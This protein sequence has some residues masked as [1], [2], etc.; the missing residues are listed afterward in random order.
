MRPTL[1]YR[2]YTRHAKQQDNAKFLRQLDDMLHNRRDIRQQK[3]QPP[4]E[5][6]RV[7]SETLDKVLRLAALPL[8]SSESERKSMLDDLQ[9]QLQFVQDIQEINV[10]GVEPLRSL[11][12]ENAPTLELSETFEG[13]TDRHVPFMQYNLDR[14]RHPG[15][16]I[17]LRKQQQFSDDD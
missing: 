5:S 8:P 6:Q 15:N 14:Q 1:L 11:H 17:H 3:P 4:I 2:L 9:A 16:L 12:T 13:S 10:S 7:T